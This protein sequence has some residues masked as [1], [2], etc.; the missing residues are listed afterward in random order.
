VGWV[1]RGLFE[2]D[3]FNHVAFTMQG[4]QQS[5]HIIFVS[6]LK[7]PS[8]R[9]LFLS[10]YHLSEWHAWKFLEF[11]KAIEVKLMPESSRKLNKPAH[12]MTQGL[13]AISFNIIVVEFSQPIS[14]IGVKQNSEGT[15][16]Q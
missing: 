1:D 11:A 14:L 12:Q 2:G 5:G 13:P 6:A 3:A 4:I 7:H 10:C 9:S 15:I 8:S 16:R